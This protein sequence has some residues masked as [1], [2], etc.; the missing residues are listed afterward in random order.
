VSEGDGRQVSLTQGKIVVLEFLISRLQS[1]LT[2]HSH[3]K[4]DRQMKQRAY[5]CKMIVRRT[6]FYDNLTS[7]TYLGS[8]SLDLH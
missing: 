5:V 1:T 2:T 6:I 8:G 3:D 7:L 4:N